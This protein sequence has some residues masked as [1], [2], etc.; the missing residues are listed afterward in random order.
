LGQCTLGT[1]SYCCKRCEDKWISGPFAGVVVVEDE[2]L[3]REGGAEEG[4][5]YPPTSNVP[6]ITI[7]R[8]P[9]RYG[10]NYEG[11]VLSAKATQ[12]PPS[13]RAALL[14]LLQFLATKRR[15]RKR[16]KS[17]FALDTHA[18]LTHAAL[19]V[20]VCWGSVVLHFQLMLRPRLG[21]LAVVV[22]WDLYL[23][24]AFANTKRYDGQ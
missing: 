8:P 16:R 4:N 7:E 21:T 22:F 14:Y 20:C 13:A 15:R 3:V 6:L 1:S 9:M 23:A 17:S 18:V 19:F 24:C 2:I 5:F 10:T 11:K 12:L